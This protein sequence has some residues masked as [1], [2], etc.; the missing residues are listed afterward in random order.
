[1]PSSSTKKISLATNDYNFSLL[2][3]P[4]KIKEASKTVLVRNSNLHNNDDSDSKSNLIDINDPDSDV[5]FNDKRSVS[6]TTSTKSK[7]TK[8]S[9]SSPSS[10]RRSRQ[11]SIKQDIHSYRTEKKEDKRDDKKEDK[12]IKDKIEP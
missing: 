4:N 9:K 2:A 1:M 12:S 11:E 3:D 8:S 6:S 7:S 10:Y 5:Q